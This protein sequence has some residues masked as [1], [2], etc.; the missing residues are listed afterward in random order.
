MCAGADKCLVFTTDD[1]STVLTPSQTHFFIWRTLSILNNFLIHSP[2]CSALKR[3]SSRLL[4][5]PRMPE[6]VPG[7]RTT[8]HTSAA[9]RNATASTITCGHLRYQPKARA[10]LRWHSQ[11]RDYLQEAKQQTQPVCEKRPGYFHD[12]CVMPLWVEAGWRTWEGH[13]SIWGNHTS[14]CKKMGELSLWQEEDAGSDSVTLVALVTVL[15]VHFEQG[16]NQ[17]RAKE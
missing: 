3:L 6:V 16:Q 1:T 4:S 7:S 10:L 8:V 14:V 11:R 17:Q 9:L 15:E 5:P 13:G 12:T 2:A